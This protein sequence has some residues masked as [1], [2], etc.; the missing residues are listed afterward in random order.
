MSPLAWRILMIFIDHAKRRSKNESWYEGYPGHITGWDMNLILDGLDP[1]VAQRDAHLT[2]MAL[3]PLSAICPLLSWNHVQETG[4]RQA[5]WAKQ[6]VEPIGPRQL[7]RCAT[8]GLDIDDN[9]QINGVD[10]KY[11]H[12]DSQR[13]MKELIDSGL[14]REIPDLHERFELVMKEQAKPADKPTLAN[15]WTKEKEA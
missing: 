3:D 8:R 9:A 14:I 15:Y 7:S 1:Q 13:A 4:S 6:P 2:N 10:V 5:I 11:P 12:N